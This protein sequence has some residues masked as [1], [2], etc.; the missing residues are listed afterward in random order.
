MY[1]YLRW[2]GSGP[3]GLC[4]LEEVYEF[5][6]GSVLTV[7][8][9]EEVALTLLREYRDSVL[10]PRCNSTIEWRSLCAEVSCS[11]GVGRMRGN[12]CCCGAQAPEPDY[13][14]HVEIDG[15]LD[16]QDD[17]SVTPEARKGLPL[18]EE[19]RF[20]A[21]LTRVTRPSFVNMLSID[22][23]ESGLRVSRHFSQ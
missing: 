20:I 14:L 18:T 5:M 3:H 6:C 9:P 4:V 17:T 7:G 22:G 10:A 16:S 1:G 8:S 11:G 21:A 19:F 2:P 23:L 12:R 13:R 15:L